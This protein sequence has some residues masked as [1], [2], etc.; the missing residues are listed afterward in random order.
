[1]KSPKAYSK[2]RIILFIPKVIPLG[3]N[4][5]SPLP[6]II[7]RTW[8]ETA[9]END[10]VNLKVFTD[11]PNNMWA[12]SVPYSEEKTPYSWHWPETK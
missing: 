11:G 9:Y 12:T 4:D 1:M 2:G 7:V 6:A 3:A 5:T 8:E 10:E